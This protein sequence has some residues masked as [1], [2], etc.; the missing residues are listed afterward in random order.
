MHV[1]DDV[2]KHQ[3]KAT[4]ARAG[5][6]LRVSTAERARPATSHHTKLMIANAMNSGTLPTTQRMCVRPSVGR[7]LPLRGVAMS[8]RRST[9]RKPTTPARFTRSKALVPRS[10]EP[11]L[12]SS[13]QGF[14]QVRRRLLRPTDSRSCETPLRLRESFLRGRLDPIR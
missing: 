1:I 9:T 10:V 8:R 11:E 2:G 4:R 6:R 13:D 5:H 14:E 3:I 7:G 12:T